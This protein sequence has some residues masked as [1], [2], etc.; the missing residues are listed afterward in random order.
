MALVPSLLLTGA[1]AGMVPPVLPSAARRDADPSRAGTA[2]AVADTARQVGLALGT[3]VCGGP[4][5]GLSA[6]GRREYTTAVG[7]V[8]A[9]AALVALAAAVP[10]VVLLRRTDEGA[11]SP[12]SRPG[13]TEP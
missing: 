6:P 10:A 11:P 7:E 3:A 2:A 13:V 5:I 4:F 1:G 8:G 12:G 9:V